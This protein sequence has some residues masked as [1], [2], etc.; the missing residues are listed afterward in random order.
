M[1]RKDCGEQN[2][3]EPEHAYILNITTLMA[4]VTLHLGDVMYCSATKQIRK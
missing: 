2:H 3:C 4:Q 1:R